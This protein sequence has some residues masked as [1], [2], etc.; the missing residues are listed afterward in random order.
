MGRGR[1]AGD[2]PQAGGVCREDLKRAKVGPDGA[3]VRGGWPGFGRDRAFTPLDVV[4]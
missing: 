4:G 3:W 2:R 1:T